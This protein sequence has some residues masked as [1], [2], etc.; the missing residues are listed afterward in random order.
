MG[1][2]GPCL[3]LGPTYMIY[4]KTPLRPTGLLLRAVT[5]GVGT[6]VG[7]ACSATGL[8]D[9]VALAPAGAAEAHPDAEDAAGEEP[10]YSPRGIV[11]MGVVDGGAL[12]DAGDEVH[13]GCG[14]C[15]S[16]EPSD[17]EVFANGSMVGIVCCQQA[18][19]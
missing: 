15:P 8:D 9:T 18:A 3:V 19:R 11:A 7:V 4:R 1:R 17:A 14:P 6:V 13:S 10:G 12:S 16:V 2:Y 5:V